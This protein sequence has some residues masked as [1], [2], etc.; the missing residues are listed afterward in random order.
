MRDRRPFVLHPPARALIRPHLTRD[1]LDARV[2]HHH[3]CPRREPRLHRASP[4][5]TSAAA[6]PTTRTTTPAPASLTSK[7]RRETAGSRNTSPHPLDRPTSNTP[8]RGTSAR[9]PASGPSRT[10]S[11]HRV[12]TTA[13]P[14]EAAP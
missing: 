5:T 7:C 3:A 12:T 13:P 10:T 9:A 2:P 14:A 11:A 4:A 1:D 6:A 8:P